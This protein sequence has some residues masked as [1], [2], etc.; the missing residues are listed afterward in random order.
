MPPRA[1]PRRLLRIQV[2]GKQAEHAVA[3]RAP[4]RAHPPGNREKG[5][6]PR[7]PGRRFNQRPLAFGKPSD[8]RTALPAFGKSGLRLSLSLEEELGRI[9]GQPLHTA[10]RDGRLFLCAARFRA[11]PPSYASRNDPRGSTD[12]TAW[13]STSEGK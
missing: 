2:D 13:R 10:P 11:A 7:A 9:L 4:A 5:A 8:I 6:F 12:L 3:G 1:E